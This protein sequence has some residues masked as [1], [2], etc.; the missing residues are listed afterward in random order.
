MLLRLQDDARAVAR[1]QLLKSQV[2]WA[3]LG[4]RIWSEIVII[5]AIEWILNG[6]LRLL[7]KVEKNQNLDWYQHENDKLPWK[8]SSFG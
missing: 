8:S 1:L 2:F 3:N 7:K 6:Q 5:L 4:M